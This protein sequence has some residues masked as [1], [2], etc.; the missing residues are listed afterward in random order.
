MP[1]AANITVKASDGTTDVVYNIVSKAIG[2]G[3]WALFRQDTGNTNPMSARPWFR[4]R[5]NATPNGVNHVDVEYC[6]PF[7]YVDSTK[8]ITITAAEAVRYKNGA[9]HVPQNIDPSFVAQ[10]AAQF[11]NLMASALVRQQFLD[12]TTMS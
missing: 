2:F 8:G 7:R 3:Q 12:Q 9:W 1:S 5:S 6:Y 10:A 4:I 11:I